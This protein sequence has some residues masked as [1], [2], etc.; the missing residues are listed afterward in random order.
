MRKGNGEAFPV[1]ERPENPEEHM[2]EMFDDLGLY[3]AQLEQEESKREEAA[4]K[5]EEPRKVVPIRPEVETRHTD[6]ELVPD[7]LSD[8]LFSKLVFDPKAALISAQDE[9]WILDD[10]LPG[11]GMAFIYGPPGSYKSFIAVDMAMSVATGNGW[12]G[13]E[14]EM[15]GAVLYIAAEGSRGVLERQVAWKNHYEVAEAKIVTLPV[16]V[17]F[18]EVLMVQAF[19]ECAQRAALQLGEPI[20]M[21][22]IDTMAR[23]FGGDENSAQEV[24]Q[25]IN[26]C[27]RF[28][29]D[30]G[31]CLVLVVAHTGKEISRGMRGSS[32]LD[33]A[34]DCHFMVTKPNEG[35]A[36]V[37]N[38]KQ[39]D[40]EKAEDMRFA[41]QAVSTEVEDRKGRIRRTLV[42]IL[43]SKGEMADPDR[44][45][46]IDAFVGKDM[47]ALVGMVIGAHRAEKKITEDELRAKFMDYCEAE[48]KKADGAKKAWIKCVAGARKDGRIMK[49]GAYYYPG[50]KL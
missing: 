39:K 9:A 11:N 49:A 47:T 17:M 1:I 6:T 48:G 25:F 5:T 21:V 45:D 28:A 46:S 40:V 26:A 30:V 16:P 31:D 24:G 15:P 36:L 14:C 32:A 34:A 12:H 18:D 20:R 37:R 2:G 10:L 44:D 13:Y 3:F 7:A 23:S 27:G 8:V 19:T 41:M 22:V 4:K 33:G 38:T 29:A 50:D 42:P 35:Q 43:E